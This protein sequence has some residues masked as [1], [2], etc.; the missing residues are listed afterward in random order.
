MTCNRIFAIFLIRKTN[1]L[2]YS[3]REIYNIYTRVNIST[4]WRYN[5]TKVPPELPSD[6]HMI[7]SWRTILGAGPLSVQRIQ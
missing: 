5:I 4:T 6:I 7:A 3:L 1:N 2:P